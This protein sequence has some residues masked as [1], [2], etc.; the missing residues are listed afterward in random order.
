[1]KTKK[2]QQQTTDQNKNVHTMSILAHSQCE[3]LIEQI[4]LAVQEFDVLMVDAQKTGC[5]ICWV[6]IYIDGD[7][8]DAEEKEILWLG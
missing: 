7:L 5:W 8:M 2:Q 6:H 4:P 1:M 3:S